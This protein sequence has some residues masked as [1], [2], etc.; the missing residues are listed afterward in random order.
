MEPRKEDRKT[1]EGLGQAKKPRFSI[2]KLEERIAPWCSGKVNPHG[3]CVG[4]GHKPPY[5]G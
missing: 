3:K 1:T 4:P 2:Q 5:K